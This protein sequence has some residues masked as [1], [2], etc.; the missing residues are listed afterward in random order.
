MS[1]CLHL[2]KGQSPVL[3]HQPTGKCFVSLP[4]AGLY[5]DQPWC[6]IHCFSFVPR[7]TMNVLLF[8]E[9]LGEEMGLTVSWSPLLE[10]TS[11]PQVPKTLC[12]VK[13][14]A[15]M[16]FLI[17]LRAP[18]SAQQNPPQVTLVRTSVYMA[19]G[20]QCPSGAGV[21]PKALLR[22]LALR[23]RKGYLPIFNFTSL[24]LSSKKKVIC[25]L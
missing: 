2:E 13:T 9:C 25:P 18:D 4:R 19:Q 3:S 10:C 7:E 12:M 21:G 15:A 22:S 24:T 23:K 20:L 8:Y 1:T 14:N 17:S 16:I 6:L 11:Y 5:G